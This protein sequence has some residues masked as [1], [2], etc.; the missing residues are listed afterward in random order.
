[1]V[2]GE[3]Q[4]RVDE[5]RVLTDGLA[6]VGVQLLPAAV[7][8][9]LV[10]DLGEVV[11]GLHGVRAGLAALVAVGLLAGDGMRLDGLF[12]GHLLG[13]GV[14]RGGAEKRQRECGATGAGDGDGSGETKR[15]GTA[16]LTL[17]GHDEFLS[18]ACEVSCR[19]RAGDARPRLNA[20]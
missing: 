17:R 1:A 6:V 9:L 3:L 12:R 18:G 5:R 16:V 2:D 7:D 10:G 11:A 20:T 19:V 4:T 8:A 15:P 13:G 14:G